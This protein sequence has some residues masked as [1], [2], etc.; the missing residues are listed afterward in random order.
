[1]SDS[2]AP[3]GFES[4]LESLVDGDGPATACE[5][6][7]AADDF[8]ETVRLLPRL[9]VDVRRRM[10]HAGVEMYEAAGTDERR[11]RL[12]AV[13]AGLLANQVD[14]LESDGFEA[15]V[16]ASMHLGDTAEDDRKDAL[17]RALAS[18]DP[19]WTA[20]RLRTFSAEHRRRLTD[21]AKRLLDRT[22][23]PDERE[24]LHA[25]H[26]SLS[27]APL[28]YFGFDD[29]QP[30][31]TAAVAHGGAAG[32]AAAVE[33]VLADKDFSDTVDRVRTLPD[34]VRGALVDA[35]ADL[36]DPAAPEGRRGRIVH[37]H[38]ALSLSLDRPDERL[39]AARQDALRFDPNGLV[40]TLKAVETAWAELASGRNIPDALG[41]EMRRAYF[42]PHPF[43]AKDLRKVVRLLADRGPV[44]NAGHAWTD[45]ALDELADLPPSWTKAVRHA[46]TATKPRPGAAWQESGRSLLS[47]IDAEEFGER[48]LSW[49]S[50]VGDPH[51]LAHPDA[52]NTN[53]ARGLVWLVAMLPEHAESARGLGTVLV[54]A[55]RTP[56][57]G[58]PNSP[59]L[60]NTCARALCALKSD[61]ATAELARLTAH[62]SYTP[63]LKILEAEVTAR[64]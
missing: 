7:L 33:T 5:H 62:V 49:L 61:A 35:C 38:A 19:S 1:M 13:H 24:R 32:A 57:A 42:S 17:R 31:L 43:R 48:V 47:G 34:E 40:R 45:R 60:A 4:A 11:S 63:T 41:A 39:A 28:E 22:G 18:P 37:M 16:L 21:V 64:A 6:V 23:D 15:Q 9:P 55:L 54:E 29:L 25:L 58:G 46:A 10:A 51:T 20:E 12:L 27:S 26:A 8:P 14:L 30:M 2:H 52:Y 36:Y 44:L 50:L 3:H 53:A 59:G 56:P